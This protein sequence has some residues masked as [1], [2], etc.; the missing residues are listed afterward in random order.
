MFCKVAISKVLMT[1]VFRFAERNEDNFTLGRALQ[2]D[3]LSDR[4]V[5]RFYCAEND[6]NLTKNSSL[7]SRTVSSSF[8]SS[9][10]RDKICVFP[11]SAHLVQFQ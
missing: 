6:G 4:F 11:I 8:L 1:L 10:G 5:L 7:L 3:L 9:T 2:A